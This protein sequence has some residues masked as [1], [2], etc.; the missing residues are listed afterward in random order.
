MYKAKNIYSPPQ[1]T[2]MQSSEDD[3]PQEDTSTWWGISVV[4]VDGQ[5]DGFSA[6]IIYSAMRLLCDR[7]QFD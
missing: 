5:Q 6:G 2:P 3:R 4:C 1:S 7:D